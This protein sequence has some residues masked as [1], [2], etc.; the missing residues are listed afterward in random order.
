M[1]IV[2]RGPAMPSATWAPSGAALL[3]PPGPGSLTTSWLP[4][5]GAPPA[6]SVWMLCPQSRSFGLL[7]HGE[8]GFLP[9]FAGD[10]PCL[11]LQFKERSLWDAEFPQ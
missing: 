1:T 8:P 5:R 2:C 4:E 7:T 9:V 11:P 6:R 3:Q 10:C